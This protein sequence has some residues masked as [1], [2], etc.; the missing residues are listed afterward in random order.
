MSRDGLI[1][2]YPYQYAYR[3]S[4]LKHQ[5]D[6]FIVDVD[7]LV[8]MEI[9]PD[10][11]DPQRYMK[12]RLDHQEYAKTCGSFFKNASIPVSQSDCIERIIDVA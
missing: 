1:E 7:I 9:N 8:P 12:R 4:N 5:Y 11:H 10:I 6:S 3:T 2:S